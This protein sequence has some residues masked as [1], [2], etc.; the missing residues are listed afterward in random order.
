MNRNCQF[1][2]LCVIA[3]VLIGT[4]IANAEKTNSAIAFEQL[5]S[6]VGQ[7]TGVQEGVDITLTYTLTADGSSQGTGDDDHVYC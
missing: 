7:W 6:L 3:M 5:T 1:Q 4:S 2:M